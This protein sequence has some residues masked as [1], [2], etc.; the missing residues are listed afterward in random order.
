MGVVA[1]LPQ[2]AI[3]ALVVLSLAIAVHGTSCD[4]CGASASYSETIDTSGTYAKR[5]MVSNGCPN[6]YNLCTGKDGTD[7]CG[8]TGEEGT[9]TEAIEIAYSID[10]P[11]NPVIATET[12]SWPECEKETIAM[13]LNGVPIYGG[14]V[15]SGDCDIL[16]VTD[17]T[18]EWTSFDFCGG[19]ARCLTFECNGDYH[20][21]F[22]PSCLETQIGNMSDGHSPQIGWALDGFPV[23]GGWGP[24]GVYM[25]H[26][27]QGCTGS[28]C[29]DSCSGLEMELPDVDNFKYRYYFNGPL[30]DL[31][32]LPTDPKP[33]T[34]DYPFA[35]ICYKGCTWAEMEA[36]T[37]KCTG[38]SA[39]YTSSYTAAPL[40]GYT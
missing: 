8:A 34:T 13:A 4:V 36:G 16:D 31:H 30:S 5:T 29:L 40:A 2:R 22:P 23:Y 28:Y 9:A 6:H 25:T 15:G 10:V 11:A 32:T 20:Y 33:A 35:M 12:N 17:S 37:A 39:G 38:G 14:A 21:H 27:S 24:G 3:L 1:M 7:G 18:A 26:T 19:H